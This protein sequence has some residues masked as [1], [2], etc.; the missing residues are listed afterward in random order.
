[1]SEAVHFLSR[2]HAL[3]G[4]VVL[5]YKFYE[6][7]DSGNTKDAKDLDN[8]NDT[9]V[10]V[11]LAGTA[12]CDAVLQKANASEIESGAICGNQECS[13]LGN[14]ISKGKR[15]CVNGH[16]DRSLQQYLSS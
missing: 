15:G 7:Q 1:M 6:L 10:R 16:E 5:R 3:I 4:T 9:F 12:N 11:C 8:A 2:G 13:K 14:G